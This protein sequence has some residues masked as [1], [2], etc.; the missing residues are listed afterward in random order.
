MIDP[1]RPYLPAFEQSRHATEAGAQPA[2]G[3]AKAK[4]G[5]R[6][7][8]A[9]MYRDFPPRVAVLPSSPDLPSPLIHAPNGLVDLDR[10]LQIA[11]SL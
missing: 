5:L 9:Q 2:D 10:F 3:V 8:Q 1:C 11:H 6:L 7:R 4:L